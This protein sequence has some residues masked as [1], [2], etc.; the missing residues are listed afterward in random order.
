MT[1]KITFAGLLKAAWSCVQELTSRI[2]QHHL[3]LMSGGL[4]FSFFM[5]IVPMLLVVLSSLSLIFERPTVTAEIYSLIDL[6][7]PFPEYGA[8]V[9][10]FVAGRLGQLS[11]FRKM[12]GLIGIVG[13]FFGAGGLFSS[14]RTILNAVFDTTRGGT[15]RGRATRGRSILKNKLLDS[16]FVISSL[17][18]LIGLILGLPLL[19][20]GASLV[21]QFAWVQKLGLGALRGVALLLIEFVVLNLVFGIVYASVPTE[22]PPARSILVGTMTASMLWLTAEAAFGYYISSV[23]TLAHIYGVYTFLIVAAIWIYYTAVALIL[24]AETAQLHHEH[25]RSE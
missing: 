13:L 4:A 9:K 23:A 3:F 8:T 15:T 2:G 7:I 6:A 18:I 5:C 21:E 10:E 17:V 22:R 14:L 1:D 16:L 20:A 11:E 19:E 12:A 25:R 24:G